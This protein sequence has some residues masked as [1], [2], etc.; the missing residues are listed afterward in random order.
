MATEL[1]SRIAILY[2][3]DA[4]VRASATPANNRF[5]ALF[6]ALAEL[7][8]DAEP[9]VYHN[10]F[11][12][13][14]YRRLTEVDAVLVWFNPLE[15]GSDRALLDQ[16]LREVAAA[17]VYVS[18]HPDVILKMGTKEVLYETRAMGWGS[19]THVYRT[20]DDLRIALPA[21]LATGEARVLKQYRGNG[22]IG[23]WKIELP[24]ASRSPH[25]GTPD[26]SRIA[27]DT[28]VRVRHAQRGSAEEVITLSAFVARCAPYFSGA[29]RMIDQ[30]YQSRLR[31]G[32]F[33]C[34]LVHDQ[35]AGFGH[36][37]INALY[38]APP[39]AP[40]TEAPQPGPRLYYPPSMPE[41]QHL[42]R[43]M[44][45][46]WVPE[47]QRLLDIEVTRLPV[48][49]DADFLLGPRDTSGA[50]TYVLC[51]INVSSV[52]PYP[53]SAI[54]LMARAARARALEARPNRRI[55]RA[56]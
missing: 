27:D 26:E 14:V 41:A 45:Q 13:E 16:M 19:D 24:T 11:C 48:L 44:E 22:G 54:P 1:H 34:Y 25:S 38:P 2:P 29:G 18:A 12:D 20:L 56:V 4:G 36:Q 55:G 32:M 46:E 49:W 17:G 33:R 28:L 37:A 6:A 7:G 35:V 43:K 9:A 30:P 50:D 15:G 40:T 5:A 31:E 42:K 52:A 10:D 3:G 53:D 23:I 51:E 39:G 21:R 47:L 8:V